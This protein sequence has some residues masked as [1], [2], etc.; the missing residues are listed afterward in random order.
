[1]GKTTARVLEFFRGSRFARDVRD[2]LLFAV[3]VGGA[4]WAVYVG[5]AQTGY[6]WD[7]YRVP[8]FF[9]RRADE[10]L[11]AGP[12]V[13]GL[14]LTLQLCAV[15]LVCAMV[16]GLATAMLRLSRFFTGYWLARSYIELVRNTPLLTQIYLLYFV[17][18]NVLGVNR[19]VAAVAALSLFEGA[20]TS[21][22]LRA[23]IA[24]IHRGQWEAAH[25]LGMG[26]WQTYRHVIL[27]QAVR[28]V[29]P[30]LASQSVS[31]VKDSALLSAIGIYELTM[32]ADGVMSDK[33][34]VFEVWFVAAAM[35]LVLTISLSSLSQYI[36]R[37]LRVSA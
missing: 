25:S 4:A 30:A 14:L 6:R 13:L 34:L 11:K 21:E 10:G 17:V 9:V 32:A 22:I 3:L 36:E 1:M 24:S 29:L 15:S 35:Y 27:P 26:R 31:L 2:A 16:I 12:L 5:A 8:E 23:G 18:A 7:W 20:Y 28:R 37:R 33:F 19:F